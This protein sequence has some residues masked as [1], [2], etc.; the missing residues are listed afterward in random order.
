M[1]RRRP[2]GVRHPRRHRQGRASQ[3]ARARGVQ[4]MSKYAGLSAGHSDYL[5]ERAVSPE[6]AAARGYRT[7]DAE[8]AA[9]VGFKRGQRR[10]GLLIPVWA[11]DAEVSVHQL[12]PDD[13]RTDRRGKPIKFETPL[14]EQT[15][16]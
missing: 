9:A 7:V 6:A 11:A 4:P 10:S 15:T 5:R 3:R 13:P 1:G 2:A 8:G 12:R 16:I 14:G